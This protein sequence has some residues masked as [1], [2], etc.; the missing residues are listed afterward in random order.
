[1]AKDQNLL[2][3]VL[4]CYVCNY[5]TCNKRD[6]ER[7]IKTK[8]HIAKSQALKEREPKCEIVRTS[9]LDEDD[10]FISAPITMSSDTQDSVESY[11]K[12]RNKIKKHNKVPKKTSSGDNIVVT[13]VEISDAENE[14]KIVKVNDQPLFEPIYETIYTNPLIARPYIPG[15]FDMIL[16]YGKV[17]YNFL[18]DIVKDTS[19]PVQ[20]F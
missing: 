12:N 19:T 11:K 16:N 3:N 13:H 18:I 4:N 17:V 6:Y 10:D 7:H 20:R 8:R 2:D 15:V 5:F 14:T 1:M 9:A